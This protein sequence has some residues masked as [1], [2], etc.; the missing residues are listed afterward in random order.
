MTRTLR[1]LLVVGAFAL[2]SACASDGSDSGDASGGGDE[3]GDDLTGEEQEFADAFAAGL[4]ED[5]GG[6]G[7]AADEADCMAT[8]VM[9]EL[10]V[11]PF[12]EAEVTADDIESSGDS[13]PGDLLG[14]DAVTQDQADAIIAVWGADCVDLVQV[15]IRSAGSELDLDPEGKACLESGLGE[16]DLAAALLAGAFTSADGTPAE[17]AVQDFL[18]LLDECGESTG[19]NPIVESI[20]S[21]LAADGSLTQE[22]ADC[23]AQGVVDEIGSERLG[24]LFA[25]GDFEDIGAEAQNEVTGAL[26]Q[27]AVACDVPVSAFGG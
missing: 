11:E 15:M 10:G 26:L 23:L 24:E 2:V 9:A 16:D 14:D 17:A 3:G 22:Q 21:E 1:L 6:L 18:A 20:A 25:A 12:E 4:V 27:A 8:A 19:S 7:V 13:S 5:D